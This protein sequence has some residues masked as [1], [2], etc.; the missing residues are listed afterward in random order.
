MKITLITNLDNGTENARLTNEAALLGHELVI[1]K[2]EDITISIQDNHLHYPE[3]CDQKPDVV[4]LRGVLHSI[5]RVA[6]LVEH[7]RK[8]GIK[9]FDNNLQE[10]QYSIDK[11]SDL[12]KLALNN[13]L[14]PNTEHSTSYEKF[15]AM[16]DLIG[17]PIIVKPINT[18][19][20][21]GISKI[22][23]Q[24]ELI[25]YI[26]S[27]KTEN[28]HAKTLII[29][30]FIPY[31]FD[32]RILVIGDNTF[33][34]R[35]IPSKGEFRANYSLGGQVEPFEPSNETKTLAIKA[36]NSINMSVGGVDVLITEQ[37][38]EY[39]LEV[40]HSPGFEGME[41]ATSQNIAKIFLEHAISNAR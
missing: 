2:P 5:R 34:M 16:A 11:I 22:N 31:K 3:V 28:L 26:K 21:L 18:G 15:P 30:Q 39:I 10:M 24:D 38:K 41:K 17:Y 27:R 7:M 6:A 33:T 4:I 14:L 20:G 8:D 13:I 37:G 1:I 35:R 40:N 12:T 23:N 29:Q 36:L 32:L 9:V 19:K 25:T